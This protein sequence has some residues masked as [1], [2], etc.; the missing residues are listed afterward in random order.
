MVRSACQDLV[1][2]VWSRRRF[3][4]AGATAGLAAAFGPEV[5]ARAGASP[6]AAGGLH[7]IEH[8]VFLI[9]ENRSFDHYFGTLR[10]VRGFDAASP[11]FAQTWPGHRSRLLPFHLDTAK[12]SGAWVNDI[13]TTG[14][15]STITGTAGGWTSG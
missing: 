2:G 11:A 3:L 10:G 5:V 4:Q 7:A 1:V 9:Q 14:C 15:R 6:P 8:V 13:A 12:T